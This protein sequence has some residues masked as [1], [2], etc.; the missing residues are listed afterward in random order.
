MSGANDA[1]KAGA[2]LSWI[3][4][5]NRKMG[6]PDHFDMIRDADIDQVAD[7]AIKEANPLYPVPVIW[8]REDFRSFIRSLSQRT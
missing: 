5:T 4:E 6:L 7:W 8:S 2:F 3:E 1:E